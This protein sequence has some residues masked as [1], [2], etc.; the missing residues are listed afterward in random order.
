MHM[1]SWTTLWLVAVIVAAGLFVPRDLR[2]A[3]DERAQPDVKAELAELRQALARTRLELRQAT[4]ELEQIKAFLTEQNIDARLETWREERAA[5][6]RERRALQSER[7][8]LEEARQRLHQTT[9][10]QAR[11]RAEKEK[12]QQQA[13]DKALQPNWSAQYQMGLIDLENNT[14]FVKAT[15]GDVLV[16][17]HPN[18]DRDNVMV[19]GTFLNESRAS[20]RYTFEIRIAGDEGRILPDAKRPIV[21]RWRYQTPVLGPR[22]LHPFEVKVPVDDV[23]HI[24]VLQIGKVTADRPA[25]AQPQSDPRDPNAPA[26]QHEQG[27]AQ[28]AGPAQKVHRARITP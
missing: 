4:A 5:L 22:E 24:E 18:I 28:T 13:R 15:D 19:R 26:Y 23:S 17:Q 25:S 3:E 7:R 6:A 16:R 1:R 14:I 10:N 27:E 9:L 11:A 2:A 20:W 12:A 8:K 21:G